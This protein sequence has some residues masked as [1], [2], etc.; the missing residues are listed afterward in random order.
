MTQAEVARWM[1][2]SQSTISRLERTEGRLEPG[3]EGRFVEACERYLDDQKE[4]QIYG[5][6]EG[7]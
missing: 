4:R 5:R 7:E 1:G 2:W 3:V 6:K